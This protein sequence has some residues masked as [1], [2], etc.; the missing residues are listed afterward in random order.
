[1]QIH[2][3]DSQITDIQFAPDRLS[4]ITASKDK[5]AKV[6]HP[7]RDCFRRFKKSSHSDNIQLL[8]S[9]NLAILK[10]YISD[11]PL[12]TASVTPKKDFVILG[13]G[14]AAMDVTTT[15]ARQGKFEARFYHK[16]SEDMLPNN[17]YCQILTT[18]LGIRR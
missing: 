13:G 6:G 4:F 16:V 15:S 5:S 17:L 11:T 3:F 8:S 18:I 7:F 10:T 12:N 9:R 2:E 14:Q 1:M